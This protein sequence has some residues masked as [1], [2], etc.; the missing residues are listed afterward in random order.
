MRVPTEEELNALADPLTQYAWSQILVDCTRCGSFF[1]LPPDEWVTEDDIVIWAS[2]AA[3]EAKSIGWIG[4]EE[5][6][7]LV[8]LCPTCAAIHVNI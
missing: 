1:A 7:S 3:R 8:I 4:R 2:R 6:N 5:S